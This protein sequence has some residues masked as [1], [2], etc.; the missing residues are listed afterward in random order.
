M[1]SQLC[2]DIADDPHA[3]SLVQAF[4]DSGR[5]VLGGD[6]EEH[7][8]AA[9]EAITDEMNSAMMNYMPLRGLLSFGEGKITLEDFDAL[10][11]KMNRE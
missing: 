5:S 7:S 2:L 6:A 9:S 11:K 1:P 8:K 4:F 10:L 3:L